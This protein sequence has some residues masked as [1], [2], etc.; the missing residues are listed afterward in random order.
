MGQIRSKLD[1][2]LQ[3]SDGLAACSPSVNSDVENK[4]YLGDPG[5]STAAEDSISPGLARL[6]NTPGMHST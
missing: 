5:I 3:G 2:Q 1:R 4:E 6:R